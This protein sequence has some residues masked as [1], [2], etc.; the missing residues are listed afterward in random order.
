MLVIG[1]VVRV[2]ALSKLAI[3]LLDL[4]VRRGGGNA[5]DSVEILVHPIAL[6]HLS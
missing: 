3:G 2:I 5:E 1:V 4:C 6:T